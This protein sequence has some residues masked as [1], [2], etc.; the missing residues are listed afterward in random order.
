VQMLVVTEPSSP[1]LDHL[2]ASY[3]AAARVGLHTDPA[4]QGLSYIRPVSV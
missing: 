2:P 4:G 1:C 3:K